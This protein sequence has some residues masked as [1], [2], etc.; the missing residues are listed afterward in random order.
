MTHEY[1]FIAACLAPLVA[2]VIAFILTAL[3]D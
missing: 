3:E 2:L 1:A